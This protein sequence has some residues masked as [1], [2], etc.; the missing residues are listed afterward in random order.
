MATRCAIS[1][2]AERTFASVM[3]AVI[4]GPA[5]ASTMAIIEM[6]IISSAKVKPARADRALVR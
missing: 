6:T 5:I 2:D 4:F 1:T 3:V